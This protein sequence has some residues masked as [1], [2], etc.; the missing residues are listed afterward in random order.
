MI[1]KH[2]NLGLCEQSPFM[3]WF[4]V[5]WKLTQQQNN[6]FLGPIAWKREIQASSGESLSD[7]SLVNIII[8]YRMLLCHANADI[9]TEKKKRENLFIDVD[10][11][12][13]A[14]FACVCVCVLQW[15]FGGAIAGCLSHHMGML[16]CTTITRF[17]F[18]IICSG[19]A[20]SLMS[21]T[22]AAKT[23]TFLLFV[24]NISG[25]HRRKDVRDSQ[26][27]GCVLDAECSVLM[28]L[29]LYT[30]FNI[31]VIVF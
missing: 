9:Y 27:T 13:W 17:L 19:P 7:S 25:T 29:D 22:V 2:F 23:C 18:S 20:E 28:Q 30:T 8:F 5:K 6:R 31:S 3:L 12:C 10:C 4:S 21:D 14:T 24:K 11:V 15:S 16:A 1:H 26:P